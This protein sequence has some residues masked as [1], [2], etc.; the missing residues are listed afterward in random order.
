MS[1]VDVQTGELVEFDRAA[2]ERRAERITLR[3][4]TIAENR[5]PADTRSGEVR[6]PTRLH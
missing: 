6:V 2:A 1:A 3:L 5:L 4:D